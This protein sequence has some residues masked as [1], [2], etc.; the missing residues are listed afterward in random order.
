MAQ[1]YSI[2]SLFVALLSCTHLGS[3]E[4]NTNEQIALL[5]CG[6]GTVSGHPEWASSYKASYYAG[7]IWQDAK[8]TQVNLPD[9][10]AT[11]AW[12]GSYPWRESGV[13]FKLMGGDVSV[14]IHPAVVDPARAGSLTYSS[15]GNSLTCWSYHKEIPGDCRIAYVCNHKDGAHPAARDQIS[16]KFSTTKDFAKL[17]GNI[18]PADVY[19]KISYSD[20]G[21]CDESWT[22]IPGGCKIKFRCHG[23]KKGTTP[24]MANALKNIATGLPDMIKHEKIND[25]DTWDPCKT[26]RDTCVGG[27]V[28]HW[29]DY[30]F[31]PQTL[32]IDVADANSA[33]Q[34]ELEYEIDCSTSPQCDVCKGLKFGTAFAG[35]IAGIFGP[36]FGIPAN[37]IA[38]GVSGACLA[39][40]C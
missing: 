11:V 9:D 10:N 31:V 40:G 16:V 15:G 17:K 25:H 7:D 27:Y 23:N 4:P 26:G 24:A 18:N 34:G 37:A 35:Y 21:K 6:I 20:D 2:V 5:D 33:D 13:K 38:Q 28:D 12:D 30:T 19:S 22:D 3:A 14:T 1:S 32:S 39:K 8:E 29:V 36:E